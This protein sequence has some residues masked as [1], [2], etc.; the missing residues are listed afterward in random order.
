MTYEIDRRTFLTTTGASF[1]AVKARRNPLAKTPPKTLQDAIRGP[2]LTPSSPGFGSAAHVYNE[3]FDSILPRAVARPL[4]AKDV[5]AAV[6]WAVGNGV[7][8]RARSGGHSYAGYSTL[9]KGVVIDLRN[10]KAISVDRHAGTA[11]VGAG[12]QLIDVYAGSGRQ[13]RDDPRRARARRSASP[14]SPSAAE[15]GSPAARTG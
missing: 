3:R 5:Q 2:V 6:R 14:A 7:Q 13:G 12:A 1:A 15:W 4:D 11:T 10:L 9:Q 8:L